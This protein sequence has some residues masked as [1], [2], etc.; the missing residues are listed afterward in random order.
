MAGDWIKMRIDLQSHPK[1][2]R[3]LS[4]T[5][6]DKFRAIGGLHAVWS[7]FDTHSENGELKGYTPDLMDH[8]IGWPGFS[9][10]MVAVGWLT[11][12]GVETLSM[13]GFDEHNGKSGKRRAEDQKRKRDARKQS[14]EC[15]EDCGQ[16][17]DEKRTREEKRRI[18]N[19]K[20][21]ASQLPDDFTLNET[22]L[23]Y[24]KDRGVNITTELDGFRN[25]HAA[26]GSTYKDWQAAWRTW[27]DNSVKFGRASAPKPDDKPKL[28]TSI[29]ARRSAMQAQA[30]ESFKDRQWLEGERRYRTIVTIEDGQIKRTKHYLESE[31][32]A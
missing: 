25:Y 26:K 8:V 23:A 27:C 10:A 2:V 6:S 17:A 9:A 21:N 7:V 22:S 1:I 15:P 24:A 14:E 13:P 3:I 18:N 32:A 31:A 4:A 28:D 5:G 16:I 20:K 30:D 12:D 11:Y 29:E 19:K